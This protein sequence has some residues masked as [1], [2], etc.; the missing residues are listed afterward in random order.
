MKIPP[1]KIQEYPKLIAVFP[2]IIRP[3]YSREE[4]EAC[5][6]EDHVLS[7]IVLIF[8]TGSVPLFCGLIYMIVT[9][10]NV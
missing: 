10:W 1:Y 3:V 9:H 2:G 4:E 8:M 5:Y 7:I 6:K